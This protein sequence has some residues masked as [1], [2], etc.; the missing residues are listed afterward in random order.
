M[1]FMV[2][3]RA[4][5]DTE[6]GRFPPNANEMFEAMDRFNQGL[7]RDGMMLGGDGLQPSSKGARIVWTDGKARVIDG[8]FAE[9]KELIAGYWLIEAPSK[10]AVVQRFLQCPPPADLKS[11]ELEIRPVYGAD[12]FPEGVVPDE[13][14]EHEAQWSANKP[15][16]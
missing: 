2:Q 16:A 13:V 5:A 12:D 10:D 15:K 9:A 1:K 14:R 11:G 6:A 8:P 4:N 7:I 3:V